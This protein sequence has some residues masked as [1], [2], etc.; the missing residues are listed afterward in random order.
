MDPQRDAPDADASRPGAE[1][2]PATVLVLAGGEATRPVRLPAA[3]LV[4]AA[5]SGAEVARRLGLRVD[6]LVGDLDSVR[7]DTLA[8]L[9]ESGAEVV[10]HHR[11]KDATDLELA[12]TLATAGDPD[13]LV[14]VGGHGGRLDHALATP[15]ALA[16]VARPGRRVEA[17]LGRASVQATRDVVQVGGRPGEL[18]SLLPWAGDARGVTTEGLRW[19][20][21][22]FTLESGSTRGVSNEVATPPARVAVAEGTLLVVRPHA[23]APAADARPP[24]PDRPAPGARS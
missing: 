3:D 24:V 5:D 18:V 23:L 2:R 19:A 15:G 13:R 8:A 16:T 21:D 20:L 22:D 10:R 11:D 17:W 7:A 1:G 4:V 12:L 9:R 14:L 6:V